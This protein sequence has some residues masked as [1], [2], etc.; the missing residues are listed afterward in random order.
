MKTFGKYQLL[1]EIGSGPSGTIYRVRDTFRGIELALKV[2]RSAPQTPK[3]EF[4]RELAACAELQHP[5][6]ARVHDVGEVDGAVYIATELLAGTNLRQCL[7]E[8]AVWPLVQKLKFMAQICDGL[9]LAHRNG[10]A[11]GNIKPSNIFATGNRE[12]KILD[13]GVARWP[14]S[15]AP[16]DAGPAR[17]PNY[18]SPEQILEQPFDGRSDLFSVAILLY[19]FIG[20]VYPFQV[21]AGLIPRE[22][23]HG[24]PP[25]LRK[26]DPD[27]P[28]GLERL[29]L[30]ALE[31]DPQRRLQSADEFAVSLYAIARHLQPEQ[32]IP[33]SE[34]SS[35]TA[36]AERAEVLAGTAAE[37]AVS[38][39]AIARHL[40]AEQTIPVSEVSSAE[41]AER[42][43]V[44]AGTRETH[45]SN[46]AAAPPARL[47][48]FAAVTAGA[49]GGTNSNLSVTA[50]PVVSQSALVEN[51]PSSGAAII[52]PISVT[53]QA[54]IPS[55]QVMPQTNL[56]NPVPSVEIEDH[57][58]PPALSAKPFFVFA[59]AAAI[60]ILILVA[61]LT[62]QRTN[63]SPTKVQGQANRTESTLPT[64]TQNEPS[65]A[66]EAPSAPAPAA[67]ETPLPQPEQILHG[68]VASLW[69]AGNYVQAM[70]L[71]D[72]ILADNP[73]Q[74]EARA[75]KAKIRAAQDAED[76]IK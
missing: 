18:L 61:F 19:E 13:F 69:E 9:A 47:A 5:H 15:F 53:S 31:K 28:E 59:G 1:G 43:E 29:L 65:L 71:V 51:T 54:A 24:G 14:V 64:A 49:T 39:Q 36:T 42:R 12:A 4:C 72:S 8:G 2:L 3:N 66:V 21:P 10:I 63:A 25:P 37:F 68:R 40:L 52:A 45:Q 20:G 26:L 67:V 73:S 17:L 41:T 38:L 74:P 58:A 7:Q 16:D 27:I 55:A 75:W 50:T 56:S 76:S 35:A 30:R 32:T 44:L 23:V 62:H 33:V 46:F 22:I 70:K 11:H 60:G 57:V 34:V 48:V 6:I